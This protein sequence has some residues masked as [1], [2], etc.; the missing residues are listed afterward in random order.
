MDPLTIAELPMKHFGFI[1]PSGSRGTDNVAD[2]AT[3][4]GAERP[5]LPTLT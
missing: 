5:H 3:R 1:T 2:E 4:C